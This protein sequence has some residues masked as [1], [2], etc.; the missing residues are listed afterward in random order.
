MPFG[1]EEKSK[2]L[3]MGHDGSNMHG[4]SIS[5]KT[6]TLA[7]TASAGTVEPEKQGEKVNELD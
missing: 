2:Q 4:Y 5:K 6:H 1:N 3:E 7:E